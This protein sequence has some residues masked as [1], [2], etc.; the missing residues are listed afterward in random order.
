MCNV[1]NRSNAPLAVAIDGLQID[2]IKCLFAHETHVL[3]LFE[4][5]V[6]EGVKT[7]E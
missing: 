3:D 7:K 1:I 4:I 2:F 6:I 5:D